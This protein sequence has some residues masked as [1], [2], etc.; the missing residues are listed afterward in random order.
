M[1]NLIPWLAA[2]CL[3][4]SWLSAQPSTRPVSEREKID[5][6]IRFVRES[7]DA[8]FI[9]N[10]QS[11]DSKAAADHL[12]QKLDYAGKS[13][14][15]ARDFISQVATG[16]SVTG[17]AYLIRFKNGTEVKC[18]DFLLK[19]LQRMEQPTTSPSAGGN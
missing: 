11:Y 7:K 14:K 12:Q 13:I 3:S 6:L 15:T 9:R 18:A 19:E 16:S 4:V 1:R 10:G 5:A 8:T 17:T 2:M